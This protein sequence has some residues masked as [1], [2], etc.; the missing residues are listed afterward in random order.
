MILPPRGRSTSIGVKPAAAPPIHGHPAAR[1]S[2]IND[3]FVHRRSPVPAPRCHRAVGPDRRR[4]TAY[5]GATHR[6]NAP[7]TR[8]LRPLLGWGISFASTRHDL[9]PRPYISTSRVL[10]LPRCTYESAEYTPRTNY[11][12]ADAQ[13]GVGGTEREFPGTTSRGMSTRPS[14]HPSSSPRLSHIIVFFQ[15]LHRQAA[16]PH[17]KWPRTDHRATESSTDDESVDLIRQ[18]QAA[19]Q[20]RLRIPP[21]TKHEGARN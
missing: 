21:G 5:E 18:M 1:D 19:H 14:P 12:G 17:R 9:R 6:E 11:E 3:G 15:L 8:V 7:A 10:L 4:S 16:I 2:P 20:Y 13:L